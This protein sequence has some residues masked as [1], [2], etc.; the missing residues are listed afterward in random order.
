M[1]F[2]GKQFHCLCDHE[3]ANEWARCSRKNASYISTTLKKEGRAFRNIGKNISLY[4][5]I[6]LPNF[7]LPIAKRASDVMTQTRLRQTNWNRE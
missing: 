6:S 3:Q 5:V 4:C 2:G 1:A 7:R